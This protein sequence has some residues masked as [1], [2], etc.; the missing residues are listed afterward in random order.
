MEANKLPRG[1]RNNNPLNIRRSPN[2]KWDH[3]FTDP[4][5]PD[6]DFCQFE[7]M[8][9]GWRAAYLLISTYMHDYGLKSV[10]AIIERWAPLGENKTPLYVLFVANQMCVAIDAPLDFMDAETM[11]EL[12]AAMCE[13]ENGRGWNPLFGS[14]DFKL[15]LTIGYGLALAR[16]NV[17]RSLK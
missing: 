15:E 13:Y 7:K 14:Q 5:V 2:F 11:L 8:R 10:R 16:E 17:W 1:I 6:L 9:Y 4:V 12:G 3:E